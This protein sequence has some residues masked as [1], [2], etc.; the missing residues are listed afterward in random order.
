MKTCNGAVAIE[1]VAAASHTLWQQ[2]GHC[3]VSLEPEL[4]EMDRG[5]TSKGCGWLQFLYDLWGAARFLVTISF[6]L[7]SGAFQIMR[8]TRCNTVAK[9]TCAGSSWPQAGGGWRC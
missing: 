7:G 2:S 1:A 6:S 8:C 9:L 3:D 5:S 4:D